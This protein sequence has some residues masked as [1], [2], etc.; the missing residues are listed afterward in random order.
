MAKDDTIHPLKKVSSLLGGISEYVAALL[1]Y[2]LALTGGA[3]TPYP[4]TI[5]ILTTLATALVLWLLRWPH[6]TQKN[7]LLILLPQNSQSSQNVWSRIVSPFSAQTG[8][9]MS[10]V[11]RRAEGGLLLAASLAAITFSGLNASA[12]YNEISLVTCY[13][14][15]GTLPRILVVQF[16]RVSGGN[17]AIENQLVSVLQEES[18]FA[19]C[20]Y[21]KSAN[22]HSEALEFGGKFKASL[23]LWGSIDDQILQINFTPRDWVML[24]S[25]VQVDR[26]KML[27]FR[28]Q[29][30]DIAVPYLSQYILS[31]I[32]FMQE[33]TLGA[34]DSLSGYLDILEAEQTAKIG[35]DNIAEAYF[36]L[37]QMFDPEISEFPDEMRA[38]QAYT[39]AIQYSQSFESALLNRGFLYYSR[40]EYKKAIRDFSVIIDENLPLKMD[41]YYNRALA[42]ASSGVLDEA[43][44]D[45]KAALGMAPTDAGLY[46]LMGRLYLL[47]RQFDEAYQA[48][49]TAILYANDEQR[50]DFI[51]DLE[52]LAREDISLSEEVEELIQLLR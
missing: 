35:L 30:L 2:I 36:I 17:I 51:E 15:I 10:L 1:A 32:L 16:A 26:Q 45:I 8:Y 48:Y 7:E 6:I 24:G 5:S 3:Q 12:V 50:I 33:D 49:E 21:R 31:Q 9:A 44:V 40:K 29:E 42:L 28:V 34:R 22:V 4:Q 23:V 13:R 11:R 46:H 39:T 47:N 20:Y 18:R 19:V 38:L 14:T 37:G 52:D 25:K 43:I 41:A 27:E